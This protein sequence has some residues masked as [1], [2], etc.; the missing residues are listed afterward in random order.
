MCPCWFVLFF[1]AM[2]A[3]GYG[4]QC[5]T[6]SDLRSDSCRDLYNV[7]SCPADNVCASRYRISVIGGS[8]YQFFD[9]FCAHPSECNAT[10]TFSRGTGSSGR[11]ATTCCTGDRCTPEKPKVPDESSDHNGFQCSTDFI[12]HRDIDCLGDETMCFL[13]TRKQT[14]G[15]GLQC[16]TCSDFDSDSCTMFS[17]VSSCPAG[18]V[19]ASRYRI[20]VIGEIGQI[21]QNFDRFCAQ[22]SE[23]YA[24]GTF[25]ESDDISERMATTCCSEDLCTPKKPIAPDQSSDENGL[26]CS[27]DLFYVNCVGDETMCLLVTTKKTTGSTTVTETDRGCASQGFCYLTNYNSTAGTV[28]TETTYSCTP[29]NEA[30]YTTASTATIVLSSIMSFIVIVTQSNNY[31]L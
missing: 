19:C 7:V 11:M 10:G 29:A 13:E 23:C 18:Y 3:T 12:I 30:S 22:P 28:Y 4:L 2:A 31:N 1:S 24:R 15:Y 14:T 20:S 25:S 8:I 17:T 27:T 21:F 6:C 9:R 16:I 26:Q 5:I